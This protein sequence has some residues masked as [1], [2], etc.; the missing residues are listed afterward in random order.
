MKTPTGEV[1]KVYLH[2][3]TFAVFA[4]CGVLAACASVPEPKG[5]REGTWTLYAEDGDQVLVEVT[6]LRHWEYRL[7]ARTHPVSGIYLLEGD[8]VFMTKPDNPRMKAFVWRYRSNTSLLLIDEPPVEL[9][10]MRLTAS[11]LIGP[12]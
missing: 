6:E 11:E 8:Q 9:S 4:L 7:N 5:L 12:K 10:G 1:M 3:R 2:A